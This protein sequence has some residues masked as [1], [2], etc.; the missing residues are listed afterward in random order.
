MSSCLFIDPFLDV[1]YIG[2]INPNH[3]SLSLMM[4]E[5][6][7]NVLCEK[8][9]ALSATDV[10]KVVELAQH[11]KLLFLEVRAIPICLFEI[12]HLLKIT[13]KCIT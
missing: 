2:T 7:K 12:Y 5:A 11:K 9:M 10:Q 1:V 8:P 6:G 4:L 13:R 3:V